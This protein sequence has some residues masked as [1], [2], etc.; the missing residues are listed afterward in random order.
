MSCSPDIA[1][2]FPN[3]DVML[4]TS[5]I[6]IDPPMNNA[7]ATNTVE[8]AFIEM[9]KLAQSAQTLPTQ[10]MLNYPYTTLL[11]PRTRNDRIY[12][13]P[14]TSENKIFVE[15]ITFSVYDGRV[16]GS[17]YVI[18]DSGG[19]LYQDATLNTEV[20]NSQSNPTDKYLASPYRNAMVG[21]W[22]P[23]FFRPYVAI[24]GQ[25]II[26]AAQSFFPEN[27]Q[28]LGDI[29]YGYDFPFCIEPQSQL[30]NIDNIVIAACAFQY[31]DSGS[32]RKLYRFPVH[33]EIKVRYR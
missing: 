32:T 17:A 33:C 2:L 31:V 28:N 9:E 15:S 29:A 19:L 6:Q 18:P 30:R 7:G 16:N 11:R 20:E 14:K 4:F 1:A 25:T 13:Q 5:T 26:D 3:V 22:Q 8:A 12:N 23:N 24:N 10:A 27:N 21:N